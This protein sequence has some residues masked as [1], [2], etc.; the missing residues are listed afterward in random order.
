MAEFLLVD[1]T[2]VTKQ[3]ICAHAALD[4]IFL[5]E[6]LQRA[7]AQRPGTVANLEGLVFFKVKLPAELASL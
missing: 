5:E 1:A 4:E 2:E 6:W 3:N 7:T